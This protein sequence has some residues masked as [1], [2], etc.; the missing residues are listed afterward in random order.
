MQINRSVVSAAT[1]LL[2]LAAPVCA[3]AAQQAHVTSEQV[4]RAVQELERF[5]QKKIQ[6]NTEP[7]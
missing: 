5:V 4:T 7:V 2:I 3:A 1:S 6:E